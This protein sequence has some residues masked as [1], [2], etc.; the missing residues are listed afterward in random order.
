MTKKRNPNFPLADVSCPALKDYSD[1]LAERDS[2]RSAISE[3]EALR[4]QAEADAQAQDETDVL[5]AELDAKEKA[6]KLAA[7]EESRPPVLADIEQQRAALRSAAAEALVK[8]EGA[9]LAKRKRLERLEALN[10]E[11]VQAEKRMETAAYQ[12]L[13]QQLREQQEA[14]L[15]AVEHI[16]QNLEI[17]LAIISVMHRL[18]ERLFGLR[19]DGNSLILPGDVVQPEL[20]MANIRLPRRFGKDGDQGFFYADAF[21]LIGDRRTAAS[22]RQRVQAAYEAL[23]IDAAVPVR[24]QPDPVTAVSEPRQPGIYVNGRLQAPMGPAY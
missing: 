13:V 2:I 21:S 10:L 19:A 9:A 16:V 22:A 8:R 12:V 24:S 3:Q 7:Y 6:E 20:A 18:S 14:M 11:Y 5:L 4:D 1:A 17:Q 23:Q 15:Q